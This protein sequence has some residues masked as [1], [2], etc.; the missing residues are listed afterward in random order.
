MH[1]AELERRL[2]ELSDML[3]RSL[4]SVRNTYTVETGVGRL[5]ETRARQQAVLSWRNCLAKSLARDWI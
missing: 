5:L 4:C 2:A 3:V 1:R